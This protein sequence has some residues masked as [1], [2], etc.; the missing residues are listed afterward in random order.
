M[1]LFST[2]SVTEDGVTVFP[3]HLNRN[4]FWYLPGPVDLAMLPGSGEPQFLLI[5]YTPDVASSGVKGVGFLNVTVC[6][7]LRDETK[8]RLMGRIRAVWPD[9]D[10]PNLIP[11]PFDEGTVQI[12]ALDLQ[13]GGGTS[14]AA[15]PGMFEAIENILGASSP[16]LFGDNNALFALTLSEDGASILKAA[17]EG[18]MAPVGA[19]YNMKFTGVRPALDVK[20]TADLKRVYDS[21]SV[22]VS[23]KAYWVTAGIDATFEKLRQDGAIKIEV[24]NLAGD[25]ADSDRET[26]AL[27]LF[28]DQILSTWFQPSLNAT[29]AAAADASSVQT[30]PTGGG[31]TSTTTTTTTNKPPATPPGAGGLHPPAAPSPGAGA[32]GL[33]A[34]P[35]QPSNVGLGAPPRVGGT[36]PVSAP[37]GGLVLGA[38]HPTAPPPSGAPAPPA[39]T[40]TAG[41]GPAPAP[42]APAPPGGGASPPAG[43]AGPGAG[44]GGTTTTTQTGPSAGAQAGGV[45]NALAGAAANAASA[46]SSAASQFGLSF[47]LKYVSQDEQKTVTYEYNRMDAIQRTYAPQGYFGLM[48]NKLDRSKHFLQVDGTDEFFNKFSVAILPPHDFAG[49]GLEAAHVAIDYGDPDAG[50]PKH[51]EFV[52]DA[53][54]AT[55][56]SWDVFQG[57]IQTTQY[58]YATDY[59][60]DPEAGWTGEQD[61]ILLPPAQTENRQLTLDPYASLGFLVI[62]LTPGRIDPVV[63][64]RVEVAMQY[65]RLDK[66]DPNDPNKKTVVWQTSNSVIVRSDSQPQ[67]W[68]L[69]ISDPSQNA[70][71]YSFKT[72]LK[73]G[74]DFSAPPVTTTARAIIVHD[75]FVGGIDVLV[76][77]AF[78][79]TKTKAA[80]VELDYQDAQSPYHY[81]NTLY[82]PTA[83]AQPARLRIPILDRTQNAFNYRIT[84]VGT[85]GQQ[86]PGEMLSSTNPVVL[87]GDS[88]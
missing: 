13:G 11:V 63:V 73:D 10:N 67:T 70:Y 26:Q 20:I 46:A 80:L 40:P 12:V 34:S 65:G 68:K 79:P 76:Q 17:F 33:S 42:P 3:D 88:P 50:D 1:L 71:T 77:P 64:D 57:R 28:K 49:I 19:I 9:A 29:T 62:T 6:L 86:K 47:K 25:Q 74:T 31:T 51:G 36:L 83:S 44:A 78:D 52:F 37:S 41:G 38:A 7:K 69:R 32:G 21:F 45:A 48:L 14:N 60:F 39:T 2:D 85:N 61:R 30:F 53:G 55:A 66:L 54:H 5:E 24:V 72:V 15:R 27:A 87:V 43:A 16:E 81:Q 75:A 4:L 18:D 84:T 59:A 23:A 35:A 82:L 8:Q 58:T 22:G 56:T